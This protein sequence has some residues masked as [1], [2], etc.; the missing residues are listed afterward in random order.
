MVNNEKKLA[1][2]VQGVDLPNVNF[3][4]LFPLTNWTVFIKGNNCLLAILNNPVLQGN[5]LE[6]FSQKLNL[7]EFKGYIQKE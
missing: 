3:R 2:L 4:K 6:I 5:F 1:Y 7:L